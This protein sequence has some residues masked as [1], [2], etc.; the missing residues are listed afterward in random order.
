[1][2]SWKFMSKGEYDYKT[3]TINFYVKK[4]ELAKAFKSKANYK[5]FWLEK[6][7]IDI[8]EDNES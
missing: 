5:S 6:F 7:G 1:M 8:G 4:E 2:N 3:D